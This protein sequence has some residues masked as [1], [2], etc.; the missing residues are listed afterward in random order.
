MRK[1]RVKAQCCKWRGVCL[2][3]L[4][5]RVC[6][7]LASERVPRQTLQNTRIK[8]AGESA[9]AGLHACKHLP[10]ELLLCLG[11]LAAQAF[12]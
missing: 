6:R 7:E 9:R 8:A 1:D 2:V 11:Q 5:G 10:V 4:G 3:A 12:E